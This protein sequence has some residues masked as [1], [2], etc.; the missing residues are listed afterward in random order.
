MSP[1]S[2]WV[3]TARTDQNGGPGTASV[4]TTVYL[5]LAGKPSRALE[6]LGLSNES[7]Y[8]VGITSVRMAWVSP[9][10]LNITYGEK[11]ALEF[12]AIQYAGITISVEKR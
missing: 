7:A 9:T 4:Q 1:D 3:A 8:P 2:R 5:G 10:H 11:A 12:Q 6:V